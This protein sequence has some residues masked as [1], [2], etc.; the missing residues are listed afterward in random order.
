MDGYVHPYVICNKGSFPSTRLGVP[1]SVHY[2]QSSGAERSLTPLMSW[3]KKIFVLIYFGSPG[4]LMLRRLFFSC[5]L[6]GCSLVVLCG[7]LMALDSPVAELRL[8]GL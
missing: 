3:F 6:Q 4:T 1:F 8:S 7:V 5:R 2:L